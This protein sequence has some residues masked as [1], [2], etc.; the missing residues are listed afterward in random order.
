[1]MGHSVG[2]YVAA[3]VAGVFSFEDGLK[4]I[5]ERARLMGSMPAGGAMAAILT[6]RNTV[7]PALEGMGNDV[8]IAAMNGPANTVISGKTEVV[9]A[10]VAQFKERGIKSV[11]L[12]VSHAFHSPLM[13]PMLDQFESFAK[14]FTY[15]APR[16][17]LVSNLIGRVPEAGFVFDAAY[18]RKH[19]REAVQF[20]D[21]VNAIVAQGYTT[22][23]EAG[24][25]AT[26]SGMG[27]RCVS[28]EIAATWLPS[29]AKG[30]DD[31][32]V[33]SRSLQSLWVKGAHVDWRG[34]DA[35]Y[36]RN[37]VAVPTYPFER[38]RHWLDVHRAARPVSTASQPKAEMV[39]VGNI[40]DCLYRMQWVEQQN[41]NRDATRPN[42]WLLLADKQ[43]IAEGIAKRVR[44][45][46][47]R[48]V[49]VRYSDTFDHVAFDE[50]CIDPHNGNDFTRMWSE[51]GS[52][53]ERVVS[54]WSLDAP[55]LGDATLA[56]LHRAHTLG[57]GAAM[58]LIQAVT[59]GEAN[60]QRASQSSHRR[61]LWFVTRGAQYV[62]AS[63]GSVNA[64]QAPLW[65]FARSAALEHSYIWGGLV[66][67][68]PRASA[69]EA[70]QLFS[71]LDTPDAEEQIAIRGA[72]R[73]A[74]RLTRGKSKS[75][76]A[77][78]RQVACSADATYLVTGG[79][80]G[81]GLQVARWLGERG[82]K[83]VVLLSRTPLP[84]ESDWSSVSDVEL[85][86][87]ID[88]VR[89]LE[90]SGVTVQ[91]KQVDITSESEMSKFL[92]A[93]EKS[94]RPKIRGV[95]HAAGVLDDCTVSQLSMD[96]LTAVMRP[97]VD[98]AWLL[99]RH[100]GGDGNGA[101]E[102][103]DF[104]VMFS[105]VAS[106]MGSPGQ[107]N[108]AA[109]NA[110]MDALAHHRSTNGQPAL[111]INWGPWA[112]VGMAARP[113]I[114]RRLAMQ[115]IGGLKPA[116]GIAALDSLIVSN[117][118]QVGVLQADWDRLIAR[119]PGLANSPLFSELLNGH[120]KSDVAAPAK[121]AGRGAANDAEAIE[122][123]LRR[124]V[125]QILNRNE[126]DIAIDRNFGELGLDSIMLMELVN[127]V[128]RDIGVRLF[129]KE[130]FDRPTIA[131]LAPYLVGEIAKNEA[132]AEGKAQ[133]KSQ[134]VRVALPTIRLNKIGPAVRNKPI[135]FLLSAPRSGSTLSR[136]MLAGHKDLFVPPELHLLQCN[137]MG[138]WREGLGAT[139][140]SE[141]LQRALMELHGIDAD[142]SKAMVDAWVREDWPVEK[143]YAALQEAAGSRLLIDKSPSY[144]TDVEV[145]EHAERLF[146]GPKYI[147]LVR[148][149]Y[150]VVE[151]F[152]RNRF[153][154]ILGDTDAEPMA[155]AEEVWT[156]MNANIADF[157][158]NIDS[159]RKCVVHYED[160][161][162]KPEETMKRLCAFLEVPY[163]PSVTKPYEGER[164]TD[165]VHSKSMGIGD[166]N[167]LKH[168]DIDPSLGEVWKRIRLPRKL[169]GFARRVAAELN[170]ALPV[171]SPGSVN[172]DLGISA[173]VPHVVAI[174]PKGTRPPFFC[175]APAG[176]MT[177]MYFHLPKYL[178]EDQPIYGL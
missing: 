65:G 171:E 32:Q 153:E 76:G 62:E 3:C 95:V 41:E 83:N 20:L 82:A 45:R 155:L 102:A 75:A 38:K 79:L 93:H 74:A 111:S 159:R 91:C 165:G 107:A 14:G 58:H 16:I 126:N 49:L 71:A 25:Q 87:R 52:G 143:A 100:F 118:H 141:G 57:C 166:P 148:H 33:I 54:L 112:E 2:E 53:C 19:L 136:V 170:Y 128:E 109:G 50:I 104:F 56:A 110:F 63:N 9:D 28:K 60:A 13:D 127:S 162:A 146:D 47:G 167:F 46:G 70:E 73:Y 158:A 61:L 134:G 34:F 119:S 149:P 17:P 156:T 174:Q 15:N 42:A 130:L 129:P 116:V 64:A 39:P 169:G 92:E 101:G 175:C 132:R 152:M 5:A 78:G 10:L 168:K 123:L 144:G 125:A 99:H 103:L 157:L 154:K 133:P 85:R 98:G 37:R 177:Y 66:D 81:L 84:P 69:T 7:A 138:E 178:G 108:Y 117:E 97:K 8:T 55:S 43:G 139:Y 21:G 161:V 59:N 51:F 22:F 105:S 31:W 94:G 30:Q 44:D 27:A 12:V 172:A 88:A 36:M 150:S 124:Q 122:A 106:V 23:I 86:G 113:E 96:S 142:A 163:D 120:P 68:E 40:D 131:E 6:D 90:D 72:V 4:L 35:P 18:W 160:I 1:M 135:A 147:H 121:S 176:G 77:P 89:A 48:A 164:I 145:L 11:K 29:L 173:T 26:L 140:L 115:G 67:L 137:S 151:S 80:G 24:P 114:E